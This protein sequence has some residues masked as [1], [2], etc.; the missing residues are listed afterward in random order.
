MLT[1]SINVDA[2][3][4]PFRESLDKTPIP[5]CWKYAKF[6]VFIHWGLY[7]VPAYAP[8]TEVKGVYDK[9]AE[10]HESR[11]LSAPHHV[12]SPL[13]KTEMTLFAFIISFL[14]CMF[15]LANRG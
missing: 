1:I 7:A 4:Q 9:Y 13:A 12:D 14:A 8:T 11:L 15:K 6:G 5:E 2:S 10:H 3:Y